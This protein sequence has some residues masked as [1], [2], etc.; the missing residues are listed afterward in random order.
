MTPCYAM[1]NENKHALVSSKY[2]L[3]KECERL[4]FVFL[5]VN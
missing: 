4:N 3:N 5:H 2:G 1:Q